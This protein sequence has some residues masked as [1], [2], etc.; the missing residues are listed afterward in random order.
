MYKVWPDEGDVDMFSVAEALFDAG[1]EHMLM[2]DHSPLHPL[3]TSPPG[4]S[5]RLKHGWA[6]Q[7]GTYVHE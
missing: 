3:D 2:P 4:S 6:F 1:Y 5:G 7:F